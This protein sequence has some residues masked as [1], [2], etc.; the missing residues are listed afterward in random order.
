MEK[1]KQEPKIDDFY[2]NMDKAISMIDSDVSFLI[3]AFNAVEAEEGPIVHVYEQFRIIPF[4]FL[5]YKDIITL[6][7][8]LIKCGEEADQTAENIIA[9]TLAIHFYEFIED[10]GQVIGSRMRAQI[11]DLPRQEL[12]NL[13]LNLV[14]EYFQTIKDNY[15]KK[16]EEVRLNVSAH[17]DFDVRKQIEIIKNVNSDIYKELFVLTT[18]FFLAFHD[19]FKHF[20][21]S[22]KEM[23]SE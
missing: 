8:L 14:A 9:R 1:S 13:K 5:S 11:K 22:I 20:R 23:S 15:K 10:M 17:K 4:V 18:G 12:L 7:K 3:A 19:F 21:E 16:V 6:S 2:K